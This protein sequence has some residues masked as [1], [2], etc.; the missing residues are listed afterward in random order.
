MAMTDSDWQGRV[1]R[2]VLEEEGGWIVVE[3]WVPAEWLSPSS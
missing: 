1:V 2:P 3:E